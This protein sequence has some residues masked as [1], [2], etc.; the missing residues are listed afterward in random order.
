MSNEKSRECHN[1]KPQP[2]HDTNRQL[3]CDCFH[4]SHSEEQIRRVFGDNWG[5]ILLISPRKH[6]LWVLIRI[7]SFLW[8]DDKN[9]PS[10]IIKYPPYL[11]HWSLITW[12]EYFFHVTCKKGWYNNFRFHFMAVGISTFN[13]TLFVC[14]FL[15]FLYTDTNMAL[16][17]LNLPSRSEF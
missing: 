1:Q 17:I 6:M 8:R 9:Y 13:F 10:I 2:T 12:L 3:Q 16:H 11:L 7:T 4:P 5:I 14:F 15:L